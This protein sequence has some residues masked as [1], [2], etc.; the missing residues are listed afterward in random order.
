MSSIAHAADTF[1]QLV[2]EAVKHADAANA[3]PTLDA[4]GPHLIAAGHN[5]AVLM[6]CGV[7]REQF[8]GMVAVARDREINARVTEQHP[9]MRPINDRPTTECVYDGTPAAAVRTGQLG[10]RYGACGDCARAEDA[11]RGGAR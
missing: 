9:H 10:N 8:A 1:Q 3:A 7:T 5:V 11:M 6:D 4:A 2:N